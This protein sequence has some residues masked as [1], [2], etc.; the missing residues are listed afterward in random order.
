MCCF[1][2][3]LLIV[4]R[5]VSRTRL[6]EMKRAFNVSVYTSSVVFID[7]FDGKHVKAAFLPVSARV[8][9]SSGDVFQSHIPDL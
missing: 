9:Q 7:V 6:I 4:F 3:F 1:S 5:A 2:I 8:L